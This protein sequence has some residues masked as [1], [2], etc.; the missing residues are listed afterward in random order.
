MSLDK[1]KTVADQIMTRIPSVRGKGEEATK[2]ALILPM[3]DALGYDIWNIDEVC[4]EFEADFVIKKTG[5]KEKVDIAILVNQKPS[6]FFEVKPVDASLDGH[7]GQLARY[8]NSVPQVTLGILTN[9]VEW[10]FFTDTGEPNIMDTKPFHVTRLD[11]V[12]QGL[13]VMLRFSKS[14]FCSIAIRDYATELLYTAKISAFLRNEIDLKDRE[15]G[16]NFIRWIL[17]S[18]KMYDG[19]VNQNV[20]E[21]FKPIVKNGLTRVIREIV[22]RSVNAMDTEAATAQETPNSALPEKEKVEV[23]PEE[24]ESANTKIHTTENELKLFEIAKTIFSTSGFADKQIYDAAIRKEVPLEIYYKDTTGYFGIYLNKSSWWLL[25]ANLEAKKQPWIGFNIDKAIFE[26][27]F[28]PGLEVLEAHPFSEC[29]LLISGP[30]D[31]QKCENLLKKTIEL[32][33]SEKKK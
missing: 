19:V 32:T 11:T 17:K 1:L 27:N 26:Q 13:D 18:E 23:V 24:I 31:L 29:R 2:Q 25:R 33:I 28:P 21:R 16:E 12:D 14:F 15:P 4:P 10:R 20:I 8:Y 3:I 30:E 6:I 9:G 5:Q 22:R 7:E